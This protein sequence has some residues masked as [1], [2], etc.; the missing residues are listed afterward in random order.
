MWQNTA[1]KNHSSD[2]ASYATKPA[3]LL[4]SNLNYVKCSYNIKSKKKIYRKLQSAI[5]RIK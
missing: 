4:Q 5:Y 2:I 3:P 1:F